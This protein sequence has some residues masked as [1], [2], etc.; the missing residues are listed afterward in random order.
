MLRHERC[1]SSCWEHIILILSN[2]KAMTYENIFAFEIIA[3]RYIFKDHRN[4]A[5]PYRFHTWFFLNEIIF[6]A[7]KALLLAYLLWQGH[8]DFGAEKGSKEHFVSVFNTFLFCHLFNEFD[9]RLTGSEFNVLKGLQRNPLF[10]CIAVFTVV[11]QYF[12]VNLGVIL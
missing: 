10:V 8:A 4:R 5:C 12:L 9:A 2:L 3:V 1:F 6:D 7:E 11:G